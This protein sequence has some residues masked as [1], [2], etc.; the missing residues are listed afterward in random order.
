M[1]SQ[2]VVSTLLVLLTSVGARAGDAPA[3]PSGP[4]DKNAAVRFEPRG[5]GKP[6]RVILSAKAA[7]RLG[8]QLGRVGQEVVVRHQMVSGMVIYPQPGGSQALAAA[9]RPD[10][11]AFGGGASP[12]LLKVAASPSQL[13]AANPPAAGPGGAS[14]VVVTLSPGEFSRIA[15]DKPARVS[16]LYTRDKGMPTMEA[17]LSDAPPI[18]D[19]KRSMLTLHYVLPKSDH[20]LAPSTRVRV[21]LQLTGPEEPQLV[22]P[23]DAVYFDA[24]GAAWVYVNTAALTYERHPIAIA[25]VVGD[26]AVLAQGPAPGTAVVTTGAALLY[27][28]EIFGK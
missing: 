28:T 22:V 9:G 19:A 12:G 14:H 11:A 27:G 21:D 16:P 10:F 26:K 4:P 1:K 15:R 24:K 8:V 18:E 7:E 3:A 17:P 2:F 20:G 6:K 13:L 25:R 5:E 23:Y